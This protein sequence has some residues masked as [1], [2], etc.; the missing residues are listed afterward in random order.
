VH[1]WAHGRCGAFKVNGPIVLGHESSGEIAALGPGVTGLSV[2]TRVALEPG[3]PCRVC[4]QCRTGRYNLCPAVA[5][6]ATPPFDGTLAEYVVHAAD[7]C[8][9]LPDNV[10][11]EE[12]AL[13]EPL[14]VGVHA[15]D[16][17]VEISC[18]LADD[19]WA[20]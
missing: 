5:F 8:F 4:Q 11:L 7:Y 1:Y 20:H 15:C 16:R 14:S 13:I 12:G 10:S 3:V 6:H 2:G 17:A 19:F 18:V 9:A